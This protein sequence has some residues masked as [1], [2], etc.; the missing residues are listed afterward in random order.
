MAH[1]RTGMYA[2][3]LDLPLAPNIPAIHFPARFGDLDLL[4]DNLRFVI[5][6][7]SVTLPHVNVTPDLWISDSTRIPQ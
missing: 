3:H 5:S 6:L 7:N 2:R 4:R 1:S